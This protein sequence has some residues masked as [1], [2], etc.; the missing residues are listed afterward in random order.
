MAE[1]L[2]QSVGHR[3]GHQVSVLLLQSPVSADCEASN[4]YKLHTSLQ[5]LTDNVQRDRSYYHPPTACELV[6][7]LAAC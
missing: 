5:T 3:V 1:T 6:Q 4:L 7:M 2:H